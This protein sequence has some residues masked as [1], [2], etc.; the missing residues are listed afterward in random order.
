MLNAL[1]L[2]PKEVSRLKWSYGQQIELRKHFTA[3]QSKLKREYS[4]A[5]ATKD[6]AAKKRI[7]EEWRDLQKQKVRVRPFF[8]DDP[9]GLPRT[10]IEEL[11]KTDIRQRRRERRL[12]KQLGTKD[13]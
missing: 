10:S 4:E 9:K 5:R 6:T 7:R 13:G 1:G 8:S 2:N 3:E 12:Q 11:L